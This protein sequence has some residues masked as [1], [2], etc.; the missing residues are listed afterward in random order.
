MSSYN[1]ENNAIEENIKS[2]ED[3]SIHNNN[4]NS[5]KI[6]NINIEQN[7]DNN[8]DENNDSNEV[9]SIHNNNNSLKISNI[10]I[11][12]NIDNNIDENNDSNEDKSIHNNNNS[13]KISNIN[14]EKNLDNNIEENIDCRK[15]KSIEINHFLNASNIDKDSVLEKI[16]ENKIKENI[17]SNE[18][19]QI[20]NNNS[21]PS[22]NIII[23]INDGNNFGNNNI[24]QLS[25]IYEN[26]IKLESN[27]MINDNRINS[28]RNNSQNNSLNLSQSLN[29]PILIQLID[30][31]YD[32][33]YSKRIIH[34][35]HPLNVEEA[36]D[37]L[38]INQGIIQHRFIKDRNINNITCYVC[39]EKKETHLGYI[40]E[41]EE[42]KKHYNDSDINNV[43]VKQGYIFNNIEINNIELN[44][45][46]QKICEIC[47]EVFIPSDENTVK[48]C[49][50]SYCNSCWYDF[51]SAQIQ[52]NKLTSI[53]CLNYE[54]QE[55]LN[56]EFIL[57]LLNNNNELI[58]KYKKYKLEYEILN[59]PNKKNCPFPNCDSY[60]E[61][62]DP[63]NKDVTCL[64]NHTFC[65]SCLQKPH[66]KLACDQKL[67]ISM[68]EFAKNNFVKKC[69]NCN[70]ITEK[71][72]GCN[73]MTCTKCKYQWCWLCNGKYTYEH[74]LEGKCKGYQFFRPKDEN[75]IQLAFEGK[76]ELNM[77]QRQ[78]D[79]I[80][81]IETGRR[82]RR[83]NYFDRPIR[84]YGCCLTSIIFFMYL[85]IG[86]SFYSLISMPDSYMR[87]S[88]TIILICASYFFLEISNIFPIIY[89][90]IIM[91][92]P[93][94]ISHGFYGFI[95]YCRYFDEYTKQ[96][97]L[98]FTILLL[99]LNIFFG[100]FFHMLLVLYKF[101]RRPKKYIQIIFVFISILFEI[102]YFQIQLLS[103]LII[104]L[105]LLY[106]RRSGMIRKLND[107]VDDVIGI[108]FIR[109]EN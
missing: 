18:D 69:P 33:I 108:Q 54:C 86:H 67:D 1:I 2:N 34:Y 7:I 45:S 73:H 36:I 51:F 13:L 102:I 19:K 48:Q 35:F 93:Y 60:L 104:L 64:N 68:V 70:I 43:D 61:L 47:S 72:S 46:P 41:N 107:M 100:G 91:L 80:Y 27:N 10:N 31:G 52:E 58:K 17:K 50:H 62:K 92:L 105:L 74:Y 94:L 32:P 25:N 3:K 4:N 39:G 26:N 75:E 71:S 24:K 11:E 15:E 53:K 81:D 59:N 88:L 77:S 79:I 57:H 98:Y 37:Y 103:N 20:E 76:I 14:I 28:I 85:I 109:N 29:N 90:N 95:H 16:I 55:S 78:Q 82:L 42:D 97:K 49:G 99:I 63:K 84:R 40:P 44:V 106:Y 30:F 21:L 87:N 101:N 56:D 89:F 83:R 6:S 9:K 8:I 96:T 65:F 12:Q 5:L 66:G 22:N 23:N 38:N